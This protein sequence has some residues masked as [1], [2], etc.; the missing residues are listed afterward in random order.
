MVHHPPF[1][2]PNLL[3]PHRVYG[4]TGLSFVTALEPLIHHI[5][6]VAIYSKARSIQSKDNLSPMKLW[7]LSHGPSRILGRIAS[8]CGCVGLFLSSFFLFSLSLMFYSSISHDLYRPF[9][10]PFPLITTMSS[11]FLGRLI[12]F[13]ICMMKRSRRI[14]LGIEYGMGFFLPYFMKPPSLT[15]DGWMCVLAFPEGSRIS[16]ILPMTSWMTPMKSSSYMS[17]PP[18][19]PSGIG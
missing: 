18:P 16:F 4:L 3:F 13:P 12:F 17:S 14:V 9:H 8:L 1:S 2:Y 5:T 6:H 7:S 11:L 15:F 19:L 10:P